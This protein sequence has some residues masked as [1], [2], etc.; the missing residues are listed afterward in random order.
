MELKHGDAAE[1]V[2][3]KQDPGRAPCRENRERQRDPSASGNH[4][5]DP[6]GCVEDGDERAGH[7]A[8]Q[9]AGHHRRQTDAPDR[10]AQRVRGLGRFADGAQNQPGS[11]AVQEPDQCQRD[12]NGEVDHRRLAK[13]GR[14]EP[15]NVGEQ[16]HR[17]HWRRRQILAHIGQA[18]ESRQAAPEQADRQPAGVL[19]GVQPDHQHA[20]QAGHRRADRGAGRQAQRRTA[21]AESHGESGDRRHQQDALG[22]QVDHAGLFVEQQTQ[23]RQ[24]QRRAG[25]QRGGDQQRDS[26]QAASRGMRMFIGMGRWGSSGGPGHRASLT[27]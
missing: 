7:A 22:P 13:Q 26:V 8:Q 24:G 23:R 6:Q 2:R 27:R 15:G 25:V 18:G 11:G 21:R 17:P 10:V 4:A 1:Q 19:V 5:L 20:E 12:R 9:P 3:S 16:W 14:P